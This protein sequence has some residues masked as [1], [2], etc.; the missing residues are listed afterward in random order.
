MKNHK[1][2]I[3]LSIN[4]IIFNFRRLKEDIR[5]DLPARWRKGLEEKSC[6]M[7]GR[8][9][10]LIYFLFFISLISL[11]LIF[12]LFLSLFKILFF[13]WHFV[14]YFCFIIPKIITVFHDSFICLIQIQTFRFQFSASDLVW[15][16]Q[17][18][19]SVREHTVQYVP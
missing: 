10:L 5:N 1:Y 18:T 16:S 4:F 9:V 13:V 15:I 8:R 19:A 7:K 3:L 6:F 2:S 12:N 11:I 14:F 17:C